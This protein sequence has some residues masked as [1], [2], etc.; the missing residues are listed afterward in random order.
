[1]L[2]GGS[3]G[4]GGTMS[5]RRTPKGPVAVIRKGRERMVKKSTCLT[6][7]DEEFG[8]LDVG[9][10]F[11]EPREEAGSWTTSGRSLNM[12]ITIS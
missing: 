8:L 12:R 4:T 9:R 11:V 5:S 2:G 6:D 10:A 1:V 3:E 7:L